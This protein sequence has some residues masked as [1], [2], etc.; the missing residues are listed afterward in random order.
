MHEYQYAN[1]ALRMPL[2]LTFT[3]SSNSDMKRDHFHIIVKNSLNKNWSYFP[4]GFIFFLERTYLIKYLKNRFCAFYSP[5][6]SEL[7]FHFSSSDK[8]SLISTVVVPIHTFVKIPSDLKMTYTQKLSNLA[9]QGY[10]PTVLTY[11]WDAK[12]IDKI[13]LTETIIPTRL[14]ISYLS[15]WTLHRIF[16]TKFEVQILFKYDRDFS[17]I[18][19]DP[20]NPAEGNPATQRRTPSA[21]SQ[22]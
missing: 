16:K 20:N 9:I 1:V 15:A 12:V 22:V 5:I 18:A 14:I 3:V 21:P 17:K 19:F 7:V 13:T 4:F 8:A 2:E 11:S 6:T 10:F